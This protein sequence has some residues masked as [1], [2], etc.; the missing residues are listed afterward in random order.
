MLVFVTM[1]NKCCVPGCNGNYSAENR[2]NV[3]SFP[4]DDN[5]LKKW[6]AIPRD[7]FHPSK[8]SR[9]CENHFRKES[10]IRLS[11]FYDEK[12]GKTLEVPLK[13]PRLS[14]DAI[15]KIFPNCPFYISKCDS[16]DRKSREEK[17]ILKEQYHL[18]GALTESIEEFEAYKKSFCFQT[19]EQFINVFNNWTLPEQ[20]HKIM[21][22]P[23]KVILFKIKNSPGPVITY[24]VIINENLKL[25]TY[26]Y[27]HDIL[28]ETKKI[29]TH[30][31]LN[32]IHD[33]SDILHEINTLNPE[34]NSENNSIKDASEEDERF[35]SILNQICNILES[36]NYERN[37]SVLKFVS[38][39][40]KLLNISKERYRY[41]PD[42]IILCSIINTISAHAYKF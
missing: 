17:N 3:F 33:L 18:S 29:K 19:F 2:V 28:I 7:N 10:I 41:S 20:W 36:L 23:N 32:D 24:S 35:K 42:T 31:I 13:Y 40:L 8:S 22:D 4:K 5:L 26:L 16:V 27:G 14:K 12:S 34:P 21:N 39:Q 38:E 25:E 30:S 1:P 11:T 9:V 15:P 37:N 6:L